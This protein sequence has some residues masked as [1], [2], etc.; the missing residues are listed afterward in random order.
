MMICNLMLLCGNCSLASPERW[1]SRKNNWMES[2]S[3]SCSNSTNYTFN[4]RNSSLITGNLTS[5][6]YKRN[7]NQW[8]CSVFSQSLGH[9]FIISSFSVAETRNLWFIDRLTGNTSKM[10][11][12]LPSKYDVIVIGTGTLSILLSS[13]LPYGWTLYICDSWILWRMATSFV[14]SHVPLT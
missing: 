8:S 9:R 5:Q 6:L 10:E 4:H 14:V 12:D 13:I 1:G 3:Q 2:G 11:D 7:R